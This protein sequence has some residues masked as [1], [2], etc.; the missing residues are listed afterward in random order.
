M[1]HKSSDNSVVIDTDFLNEQIETY[2]SA[3]EINYIEL[4]NN[5][6]REF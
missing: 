3:I 6:I 4:L 5:T 1:E 2:L